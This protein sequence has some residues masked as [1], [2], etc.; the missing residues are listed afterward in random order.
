MEKTSRSRW[1]ATLAFTVVASLLL[2]LAFFLGYYGYRAYS[3]RVYHQPYAAFTPTR[4]LT[5][6]TYFLAVFAGPPLAA[7]WRWA[8]SIHWRHRTARQPITSY[9]LRAAIM[10]ALIITASVTIQSQFVPD[11]GHLEPG[12]A[13]AFTWIERHTPTNTIVVN[14]DPTSRWAP[15]FTQREVTQTPVPVS[16]FTT[17]YVA[18]KRHLADV[19]LSL[20]FHDRLIAFATD[21]AAS[22]A[23]AARPVALLSAT[24]LPSSWGAALR[25]HDGPELVYMLGDAF[26]QLLNPTPLDT[27][28]EWLTAAAHWLANIR[29]R[30]GLGRPTASVANRQQC[31]LSAAGGT[32]RG[33]AAVAGELRGAGRRS[34]VYRR[35]SGT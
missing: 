25:F 6:L 18:E 3:L 21:G 19:L 28:V 13:A 20:L 23:L 15:Y 12:E 22:S 11:Q 35:Q 26:G 14:L 4:F 30:R 34:I 8:A 7:L 16:E 10:L 32:W 17:G 29:E 27:L 1:T 5:D 9:L 33:A 2:L 31:A 24:R